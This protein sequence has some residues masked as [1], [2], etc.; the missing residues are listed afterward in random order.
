MEID[1][2]ED[3]PRKTETKGEQRPARS[4]GV[5]DDENDTEEGKEDDE[6]IFIPLGLPRLVEGEPYNPNDPEW[7]ANFRIALAS[8]N[9]GFIKGRIYW[10]ASSRLA[11]VRG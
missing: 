5:S 1:L 10:Q 9:L 7:H 11:L 4:L 8:G 6:P 2:E 3:G